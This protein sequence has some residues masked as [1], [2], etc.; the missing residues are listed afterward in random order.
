MEQI[1]FEGKS[2]PV[3]SLVLPHTGEEVRISTTE[4]SCALMTE[5]GGYT[6]KEARR[7]DE[8][9]FY[10]VSPDE[11]GLDEVSLALLVEREAL[12]LYGQQMDSG[13]DNEYEKDMEKLATY[14]TSS[15]ELA[16]KRREDEQWMHDNNKFFNKELERYISG[17]MK[18]S[19]MLHLGLPAGVMRGFL[20]ELPIVV[21]QNV[22]H[23]GSGKKHD[24]DLEALHDMPDRIS[25]PIFVFKRDNESVGILTEMTDRKGLNVCVAIALA[26]E[27]QD[28]KEMLVVND[29]RSIH[30]RNV[31]DILYPILQNNSLRWVDKEKGLA[32]F[33]SA[34]QYVRQ[35]I[36]MQ[37][38]D[39]ATKLIKEFDNN[40]YY[41]K[42]LAMRQESMQDQE[43]PLTKE[44]KDSSLVKDVI[45]KH[46]EGWN[47][48]FYNVIMDPTIAERVKRADI[49]TDQ[50]TAT[51]AH[52]IA[53]DMMMAVRQQKPDLLKRYGVDNIEEEA[54]N[55]AMEATDK[56]IDARYNRDNQIEE[57][58]TTALESLN[59]VTAMYNEALMAKDHEYFLHEHVKSY[60]L[61]DFGDGAYA[62]KGSD[63]MR[64]DY[65]TPKIKAR[66][67]LAKITDMEASMRKVIGAYI[68]EAKEA[69]QKNH[70]EYDN[71]QQETYMLGFVAG[72]NSQE[73]RRTEK[74]NQS[75]MRLTDVQVILPVSKE[76]YISAKVDGKQQ[77]RMPITR[78]EAKSMAEGDLD[79][80]KVAERKYARQMEL[81]EKRDTSILR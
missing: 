79:L 78:Q 28:G 51:L 55:M 77:L 58:I 68:A 56:V 72:K 24:V 8:G 35:E 66:E 81:V 59:K 2:Y 33:S 25:A 1:E 40:K 39:S 64:D 27:I 46:F 41:G 63:G 48:D 75:S 36:T 13:F 50:K 22:L 14:S 38:L 76:Y 70:P 12:D 74:V 69:V 31:E 54:V 11:I 10:F 17:D 4:L 49:G 5:E 7:V 3:R 16:K 44:D 43:W 80:V 42:K 26:K 53:L 29:L 32:W 71:R 9:I 45:R 30:G 21:R 6:S 23:K 15:D 60:S 47:K 65:V 18:K 62:I 37:D 34:S 20:P 73:L 57:K 67:V 19:E 52:D 61:T